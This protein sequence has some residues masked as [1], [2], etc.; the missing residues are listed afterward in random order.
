MAEDLW[1]YSINNGVKKDAVKT[2][3]Q[4]DAA[5]L[6]AKRQRKIER[7]RIAAESAEFNR[8]NDLLKNQRTRDLAEGR[9]RGSQ[10]FGD[11]SLGRL[12]EGTNVALKRIMNQRRAQAEQGFSPQ[13]MNAMREQNLSSIN[14]GNQ[15]AL[16]Q[17]QIAQ[18]QSG[19]RGPMAA[20]QRAKLLS[21]QSAQ[22]GGLERDLFLKQIEQKRSGLSDYEQSLANAEQQK[23][24]KQQFNIG[25]AQR[26]KFGQ[27]SSELGYGSLGAAERAGLLSAISGEKTAQKSLEAAQGGGKK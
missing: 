6:E 5:E 10:L 19:V 21:E 18:A 14:Q 4:L 11:N 20:A 7:D 12:D 22:Q 25:Q 16:R 27:L 17:L 8:R 24:A 1:S 9:A 23:L 3:G 13:E 26:E 15:G 2:P